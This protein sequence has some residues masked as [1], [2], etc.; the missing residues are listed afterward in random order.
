MHSA[1]KLIESI[2]LRYLTLLR[3]QHHFSHRLRKTLG[4]SGQQTAVL[5]YLANYGPR[6]VSEISRYLHIRDGTTSP[7]LERLEQAGLVQRH[8]ST[9]DCRRVLTE[10]TPAGR[11]IAA[12][13]PKGPVA[14]L[15]ERL[16]TLTEEELV[17]IDAALAR[18]MDIAHI[19]VSETTDR[20]EQPL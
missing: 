15:R 17:A 5:R 20:G 9:Q 13:A 18:L 8:R 19:D 7:L 16:P 10:I 3:Y 4:V 1:D 11:E 14:R 12:Q 6:S 2:V